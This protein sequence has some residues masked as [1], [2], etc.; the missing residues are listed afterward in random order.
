M[1]RTIEELEA[2]FKAL[3]PGA[4]LPLS[5]DERKLLI[6]AAFIDCVLD[7]AKPE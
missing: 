6:R 1:A 5:A 3:E 4:Y 2:A 7:S